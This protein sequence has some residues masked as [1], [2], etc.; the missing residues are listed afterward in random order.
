MCINELCLVKKVHKDAV[1]VETLSGKRERVQTFLIEDKLKEGDKVI[2]QAGLSLISLRT[3]I[4]Y[5]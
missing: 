5:R 4:R 2:V 1:E 3:I